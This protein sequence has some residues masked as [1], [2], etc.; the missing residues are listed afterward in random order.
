M[1]ESKWDPFFWSRHHYFTY[2]SP[3]LS[4]FSRL[5]LNARVFLQLP[6][7]RGIAESFCLS[8]G[9]CFLVCLE[10]VAFRSC[11][12]PLELLLVF[13]FVYQQ[14]IWCD[15]LKHTAESKDLA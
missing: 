7:C 3:R 15:C 10:I 6:A 12:V 13:S 1:E 11:E 9:S 5:C 4:R 2:L 14:N 8:V